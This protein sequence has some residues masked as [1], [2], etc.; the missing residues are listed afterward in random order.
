MDN[1]VIPVKVPRR[2]LCRDRLKEALRAQRDLSHKERMRSLRMGTTGGDEPRPMQ[3]SE[4]DDM[5]G[6][7]S[8]QF[9]LDLDDPLVRADLLC[10]EEELYEEA[11]VA[12]YRHLEEL[13]DP[14]AY[15]EH[16]TKQ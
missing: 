10:L 15:F 16:L 3:Q 8:E 6:V 9:C 1:R 12:Y 2:P 13:D 11:L 4:R 14:C 5:F 7:V